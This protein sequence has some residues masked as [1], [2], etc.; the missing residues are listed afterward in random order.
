[1]FYAGTNDL[2]DGKTPETLLADYKTFVSRVRAKLPTVPIAFISVAPAPSRWGNVQNIRKANT[3]VEQFSKVEPNL[4]FIDIFPL[5]LDAQGQ[6]RPELFLDD[7][8]HM[9]PAGYAI[10]TKAVAPYLPKP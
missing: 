7:Q 1:M 10:W 4:Q 3:L 8:L 5:M 6:P 9:K 2:A